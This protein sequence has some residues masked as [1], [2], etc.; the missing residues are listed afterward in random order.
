MPDVT[1]VEGLMVYLRWG[2]TRPV[3]SRCFP[4]T[5]GG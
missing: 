2:K 4:V 3:M 5:C 1:T